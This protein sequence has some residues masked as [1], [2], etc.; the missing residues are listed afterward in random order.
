[1]A[2]N[3]RQQIQQ[4]HESMSRTALQAAMEIMAMKP[5]L[6]AGGYLAPGTKS[7]A[8]R[9][10]GRSQGSTVGECAAGEGQARG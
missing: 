3:G 7:E 1:M 2:F 4:D 8:S 6:E 10:C 9:F 5:L